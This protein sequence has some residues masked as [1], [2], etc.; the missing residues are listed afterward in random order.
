[1]ERI[2]FYTFNREVWY[3]TD[4]DNRLLTE[5]D[6]MVDELIGVIAD[7]YPKA[8]NALEKEYSKVL[9]TRTRN[10][11]MV[12]R[13]IKCNFGEIDNIFDI[14]SLGK[15]VFECVRCPLRG[16]CKH[17]N[18]ICHPEFD[19]A[20][21]PREMEVMKLVFHGKTNEE[22]AEKLFLSQHTVKNHI[23][24]AFARLG[25]HSTQEFIRYANDNKLYG[26]ERFE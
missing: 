12:S 18:V 4:T 13:F 16:E 1:M 23:R 11:R 8:F 26:D 21:S 5:D 20:L 15:F 6:P 22:I 19:S 3:R 10:W 24:N 17:E 14:S 25:V 9:G 7:F 2:E